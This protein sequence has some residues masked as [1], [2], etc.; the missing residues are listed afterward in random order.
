MPRTSLETVETVESL[1]RFLSA[2]Q[3]EAVVLEREDC[4]ALG[5]MLDRLRSLDEAYRDAIEETSPPRAVLGT[6]S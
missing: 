3:G 5:W 6:D 4:T 1:I 2:H